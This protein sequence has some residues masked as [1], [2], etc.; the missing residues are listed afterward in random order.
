MYN[1]HLNEIFDEMFEDLKDIKRTTFLI[2][3]EGKLFY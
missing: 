2:D 3:Y 1:H